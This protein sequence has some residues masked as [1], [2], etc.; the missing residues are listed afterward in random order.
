MGTQDEAARARA[1]QIR[2]ELA[3]ART[4]AA[5]YQTAYDAAAGELDRL[6]AEMLDGQT[7]PAS[8]AQANRLRS[9]VEQLEQELQGFAVTAAGAIE[10]GAAGSAE[11][12]AV[13]AS[14]MVAAG[15][16]APAVGAVREIAVGHAAAILST[17]PAQVAAQVKDSL[18][19]GVILGRNPREIA[20]LVR[21]QLGSS[22][23][24]ALTIARTEMLQAYRDST[25]LTYQA[26]RGVV[27]G[28][29]WLAT[30]DARTCPVCWAMHGSVHTLD[31]RLDSH[32]ACR[33]AMVPLTVPWGELGFRAQP[34]GWQPPLGADV[35][36]ALPAGD[37]RRILGPG[38]FAAYQAGQIQLADLVAPTVHPVYGPGL[39][40]RSLKD[41]V[42][43]AGGRR[44]A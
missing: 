13:D 34:T 4:V 3:V 12:G 11:A 9:L 1:R 14:A 28:W 19:R 18:V 42:A 7:T 35:F 23:A 30:A 2:R 29:A 10:Q 25:L 16:G 33:C 17:L 40:E 44:A 37:Q 39:R 38:K 20:R 24:R 26:N 41:A 5:A 8:L 36:A 6:L 32:L 15:S 31:E 43:Q 21:R 22:L 27:K